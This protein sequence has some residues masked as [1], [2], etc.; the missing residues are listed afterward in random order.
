M[1]RSLSQKCIQ[2]S[3]KLAKNEKSDALVREN[4]EMSALTEQNSD[5]VNPEQSSDTLATLARAICK[6]GKFE[7]GEGSCS[8]LCLDALGSARDNCQHVTRIHGDLAR[9][10][11]EVSHHAEALALLGEARSYVDLSLA[12]AIDAL[13]AKIG[14]AS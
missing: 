10:A 5:G 3:D 2:N 7:T 6:S 9:A 4:S 11:L 8:L 1:T 14:G 13:F 12:N